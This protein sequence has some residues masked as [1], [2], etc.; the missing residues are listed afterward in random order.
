MSMDTLLWKVYLPLPNVSAGFPPWGGNLVIIKG[1]PRQVSI[2]GCMHKLTK[3]LL[4]R[5]KCVSVNNS[6]QRISS[7]KRLE[8]PVTHFSDSKVEHQN[9]VGTRVG[10]GFDI[11]WDPQPSSNIPSTSASNKHWYC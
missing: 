9:D 11:A 6:V 4:W 1:L 3:R 7:Y 10:I 8:I 2:L 5:T